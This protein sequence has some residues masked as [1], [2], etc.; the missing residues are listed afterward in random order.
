LQENSA[1]SLVADDTVIRFIVAWVLAGVGLRNAYK[2]QNIADLTSSV[3]CIKP[4]FSQLV[5]QKFTI[6][7]PTEAE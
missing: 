5:E 6:F 2:V 4:K 7:M 3:S 1:F